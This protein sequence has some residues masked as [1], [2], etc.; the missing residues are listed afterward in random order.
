MHA[1]ADAVQRH[2]TTTSNKSSSPAHTLAASDRHPEITLL[3]QFV[4]SVPCTEEPDAGTCQEFKFPLSWPP[5]ESRTADAS[6]QLTAAAQMRDLDAWYRLCVTAAPFV[7][8]VAVEPPCAAT[9]SRARRSTLAR[10]ASGHGA[11]EMLL[12]VTLDVSVCKQLLSDIASLDTKQAARE[13]VAC[14]K[15]LKVFYPPCFDRTL[16]FFTS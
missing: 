7:A 13:H 1:H 9:S 5:S 14:L 3:S 4:S 8:D 6:G 12:Q 2:R 15:D 10:K 11:Q 16:H